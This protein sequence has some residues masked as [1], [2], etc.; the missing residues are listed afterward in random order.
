VSATGS[1]ARMAAAAP[2]VRGAM[3]GSAWA[4]WFA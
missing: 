1:A 3:G 4:W 2:G